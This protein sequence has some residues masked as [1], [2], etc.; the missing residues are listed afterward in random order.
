[1]TTI[2]TDNCIDCRFTDCVEVCPVA[3]FHGDDKQLYIDPEVC[4]DCSACIPECPVE[5]IYED[6]DIPEDKLHW[7]E[8]NAERAPQLPVVDSQV[9]PL[10]T[11]EAK[12]AELG[13]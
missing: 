13:F 9:D 6:D 12:K 1:M 5:A 4:I 2:I 8:I 11:A 10:P 3:C 7:I